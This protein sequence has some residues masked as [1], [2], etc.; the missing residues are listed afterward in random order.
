MGIAKAPVNVFIDS[1][2]PVADFDKAL[3][4]DGREADLFKMH[5]GVYLYLSVT[6]GA[7]YGLSEL[8]NLDDRDLIRVWIL[9]KTP[10]GSPYAYT[11][12]VLWYRQ[13]FPWLEDRVIVTHDK[14]LMGTEHDFLLDDRPHKA[15]A[16]KFRGTFV[17]FDPK[18]PKNDWFEFVDRVKE[19]SLPG[20]EVWLR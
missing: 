17:Y 2:G 18:K 19:R 14:S 1:D 3:K 8:K 15:N 5:A 6:D 12:K 20:N 13:H 10:S 7:E 16:D 4:K 11:E 9:T